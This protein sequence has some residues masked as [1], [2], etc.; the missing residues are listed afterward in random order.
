ML[1]F[2]KQVQVQ[3][4]P[5]WHRHVQVQL[6]LLCVDTYMYSSGLCGV[7][8]SWSSTFSC[9]PYKSRCSSST[10]GVDTARCNKSTKYIQIQSTTVYVPSSELGLSTPSLASECAP[11]PGTKG[12]GA[13]SP[14]GSRIHAV[15]PYSYDW[16]K[17]LALR[18][19][20]EQKH[21]RVCTLQ[22]LTGRRI[23]AKKNKNFRTSTIEGTQKNKF[24]GY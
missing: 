6:R 2:S 23:E 18:L 19:L 24:I 8:T 14:A 9:F 4:R 21:L 12:V 22:V 16:R 3:L 20:C 7:G 5:L 10:C 17:G 13:H 15:C 11:P 1:L